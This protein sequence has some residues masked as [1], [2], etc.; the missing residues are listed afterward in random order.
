MW[1]VPSGES[2]RIIEKWCDND[3]TEAMRIYGMAERAGK[4]NLTLRSCNVGFP[5]PER[6]R[7][8]MKRI[9]RRSSSGKKVRGTREVIPME[10]ANRKGIF[11]CPY[12]MK[13]RR[14]QS[15]NGFIYEGVY[16]PDGRRTKGLYCPLCGTSHRDMHVRRWNPVANRKFV[17]ETQA[18]IK[19]GGTSGR[20]GG[21]TTGRR[22]RRRA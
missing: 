21:R 19:K 13:M 2:F 16:V 12:C 11:W 14:F 8:Y 15:Q 1:T 22:Q 4:K 7:P 3:L 6:F 10:A 20:D 5:P 9:V 18:T 17:V